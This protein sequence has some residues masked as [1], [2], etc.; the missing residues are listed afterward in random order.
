M[1]FTNKRGRKQQAYALT[2]SAELNILANCTIKDHYRALEAHHCRGWYW[3]Y[4][5]AA[6][7]QA[8]TRAR[9]G[10]ASGPPRLPVA[11]MPQSLQTTDPCLVTEELLLLCKDTLARPCPELFICLMTYPTQLA[12]RA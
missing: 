12:T 7:R 3:P 2:L 10:G 1:H 11:D 5:E 9:P 6:P 8:R 4:G